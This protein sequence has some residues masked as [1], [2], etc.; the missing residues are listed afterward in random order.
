[1]HVCTHVHVDAG[2]C[3]DHEAASDVYPSNLMMIEESLCGS[4][5][6]RPCY[7]PM[8]FCRFSGFSPLTV[9]VQGLRGSTT[10]PHYDM[11]SADSNAGPYA[12]VARD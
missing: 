9:G 12:R 8:S 2:A 6:N 5:L 7:V 10:T 1:M 4:L 11:G 3:G